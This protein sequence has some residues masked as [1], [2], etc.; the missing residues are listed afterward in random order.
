[1]S[2][3][4]VFETRFAAAYRAYLDGAPTQVDAAAVARNAAAV[5][6]RA[7]IRASGWALR[8]ARAFA[9]LALLALLL[10][11]LGAAAL[12]VGSQQ[13]P[14]LQAVVPPV[15]NAFVCPPGS[16]P[17]EPGPAGQARPRW[18]AH[19]ALA[20]DRR[21]GRLM[22]LVDVDDNVETWTFDVCANTWTQMHPSREPFGWLQLVY[23][24]RAG[25]TI[26]VA[27]CR[28]CVREP[29]GT[30]WAYDLEA[31]AWSETGAAPTGVTGL[32][33]EPIAG[34]V[35]A[36]GDEGGPNDDRKALWS[37]DVETGTWTPIRQ[38]N[39]MSSGLFAYDTSVYR[40]I[41]YGPAA[42]PESVDREIRLFDIRTGRWSRSGAV[43]P[44]VWGSGMWGAPPAIAFD[45]A[46][47]RTV[48]FGG[49]LAAYDAAAERWEILIDAADRDPSDWLPSALVY[50]S[51]NRR[52]VGL[53]RGVIVD[54]GGLVAFDLTTRE[55]TVL[56]GASEG[57]PVR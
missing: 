11:T 37:Y 29:R 14:R 22:V 17:D 42:D 36:L 21:A 26:G 55:W 8:P 54:R 6:P 53:G 57:K 50:D 23:D 49:S 5:H 28:D 46:A 16:N 51:V 4:E 27:D 10:A 44:G 1:M 24:V 45:E 18:D 3:Q 43:T 25:L 2:E 41:T 40:I 47:E 56:L 39:A 32:S 9:W 38:A 33:Y 35:V 13:E 7:R 15:G 12:F 48:V 34:L 31:N 52:L 30:V 19:T 20:F